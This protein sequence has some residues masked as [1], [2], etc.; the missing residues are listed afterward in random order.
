MRTYRE[1]HVPA[2]NAVRFYRLAVLPNL[3]GEWGRIGQGSRNRLDCFATH[4][5]AL[6]VLRTLEAQKRQYVWVTDQFT[7]TERKQVLSY[8]AA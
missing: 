8:L 7:W 6:A 3:F 5:Q 4:E 1:K 2:K